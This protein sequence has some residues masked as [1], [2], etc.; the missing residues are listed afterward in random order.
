MRAT[1]PDITAF[2]SAGEPVLFRAGIDESIL[3]HCRIVGDEIKQYGHESEPLLCGVI[4]GPEVV[5]EVLH[6]FATKASI[7][8][9]P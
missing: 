7:Q 1:H 5:T 9:L 3:N 6:D 4:V 8:Q 2:Q